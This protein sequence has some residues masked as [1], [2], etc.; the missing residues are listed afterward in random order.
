MKI[1][2]LT[3]VN[4]LIENYPFMLDYLIAYNQK[5]SLLRS[6]AMRMTL[7]RV[8]TLKKVAAMGDISLEKLLADVAAKIEL[9]TGVKVETE[10]GRMMTDAEK[11]EI[12]K[13][14]IKE[15]HAGAPL[16]RVKARFDKAIEGLEHSDIAAMEEQLIKEGVEVGQ[17]QHLCDLHVGVFKDSLD[18]M[19][20]VEAQP[21]H[22][23]HT[24]ME[25]NKII[26]RLINEFGAL[27]SALDAD[28]SPNNFAKLKPQLTRSLDAFEPLDRHYKRKEYQLFPYLERH[29]V[30][31][32]PKVM[33]GVHDEIRAFYKSAKLAL[34]EEKTEEF[35]RIAAAFSRSATEMVY[36]ED[37]ILFPISMQTLTQDD[38]IAAKRGE[39]EIGYDFV[40]PA[41]DGSGETMAEISSAAAFAEGAIKLDTGELTAEQLNAMLLAMP[42]DITFVDENDEVRYFSAGPERVFPRSA[43]IIGRKVQNCHPPKSLHVVNRILEEFRAGKKNSADFYIHLG[44]KFVY[45]R[46][47]A[48]RGAE[49]KYMGTLEV[50]Q[51]IAP[52]QAIEGD[53][54]LLD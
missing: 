21:G 15:L 26:V 38:W 34:E 12:L 50:T 23:V 54:R 22:P 53:K 48:V 20:E 46:Y 33:W 7:G 43:G 49:G 1:T 3:K 39:L 18:V 16:E 44:D 27:L 4:D 51:D 5:F 24:Y 19:P 42:V 36:K 6:K 28:K 30:T 52:I 47:F 9:E 29:G 41:A 35:L 37:R 11:A 32:P 10:I 25:S 45:I 13:E 31:A 2:P 17:I 14:I 40:P 8:A